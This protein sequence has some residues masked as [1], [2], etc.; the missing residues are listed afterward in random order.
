M[1]K[2]TGFWSW[3]LRR[4]SGLGLTFYLIWHILVI[5]SVTGGSASFDRVM[6]FYQSPVFKFL[7]IVLVG[8]LVYHG[9]DGI[10]VLVV[11]LWSVPQHEKRLLWAVVGAG[12]VIFVLGSLPLALFALAK[13]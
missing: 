13:L 7:E 10:R 6:I 2:T 1:Y 12:V 3:I 5:R 4:V 8:G 9:L 11:D